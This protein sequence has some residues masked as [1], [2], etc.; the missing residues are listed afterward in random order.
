MLESRL[1]RHLRISQCLLD[2]SF[3]RLL[4]NLDYCLLFIFENNNFSF[5]TVE[6]QF[7]TSYLLT[8]M[9]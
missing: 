5:T 3:D 7:I 8:K 4:L 2:E 1:S 9:F 6:R